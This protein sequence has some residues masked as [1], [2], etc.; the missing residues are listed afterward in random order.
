MQTH[1]LYKEKCRPTSFIVLL[2][3]TIF[4]SSVL[5]SCKTLKAHSQK[6]KTVPFD[7]SLIEL[8]RL[9]CQPNE[10]LVSHCGFNLSFNPCWQI[11]NWVAYELTAEETKGTE[12]RKN[13][14]FAKDPLVELSPDHSDY[15]GSG[16]SR[17]HMAPAADMKWDPCAMR[18]SFFMTNICPQTEAMNNG[19]WELLERKCRVWA[20]SFGSIYIACGPVVKAG[21]KTISAKKISVPNAFYKVVLRKKNDKYEG[22]AFIMPNSEDAVAS[23]EPYVVSIDAVEAQTGIDFFYNLPDDVEVE[24]EAASDFSGWR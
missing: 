4:L 12:S 11:S 19:C 13:Y 5:F 1:I 9:G 10:Q 16:Y 7:I 23:L 6:E 15:S 8:P 22:I 17:G 24:V 18:S 20:K 3:G 14:R 2:V 21:M